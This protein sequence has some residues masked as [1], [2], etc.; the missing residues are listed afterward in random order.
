MH[1]VILQAVKVLHQT[2]NSNGIIPI[3]NERRLCQTV[4]LVMVPL[5]NPSLLL[6]FG[7]SIEH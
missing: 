4:H 5:K 6:R 7:P 2:Y 1:C 3:I